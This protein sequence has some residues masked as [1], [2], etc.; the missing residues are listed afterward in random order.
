[1]TASLFFTMTALGAVFFVVAPISAKTI[2]VLN[3]VTVAEQPASVFFIESSK[4]E[5]LKQTVAQAGANARK[6][7]ILVV[8]GHDSE[9]WGTQYKGVKEADMTLELG[10]ELA[11]LLSQ[12]DRFDV[13]LSRD[14]DGYMPELA[15]Y[16]ENGKQEILDYALSKKKIMSDLE[17]AGKISLKTDGVPHNNAPGP[18][19]IRLYGINKWANENN[20][21]LVIHVHFNDYPRRKKTAP[22]DYSGFSIYVPEHQYS[23]ARSSK[24]IA[25]AVSKQLQTYYPSSNMPKEGQGV[26]VVEDQDLI[27]IGSF[28][29]LD[30]ASILVEYGYI[31]EPQFLDQTIRSKIL[32]DLATQTYVGVH[33][34]FGG[35]LPAL[36]GKYNT[37]LLPHTWREVVA[38]GAQHNPSILSLQ[39]ALVLEGVYPPKELDTHI[40]PL[41]G[42]YGACTKKSLASFQQKY[43]LADQRGKLGQGTIQKLNELYGE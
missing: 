37:A 32:K 15:S 7:R 5:V 33:N 42:T 12:E 8:P 40:C 25:D 28:N 18:V 23:N 21:D 3:S 34:F 1:V 35:S 4:P 39:A 14:D 30:P 38:A 11:G 36:A 29:T 10:K 26:G 22:G 2:F 17:T 19:V 9:F 31:Y 41:A 27:A 43:N 16:F 13:T 24:D 6:L 20:I